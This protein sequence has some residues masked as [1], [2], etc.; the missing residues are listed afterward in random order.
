MY[1]KSK[2]LPCSYQ[3]VS[4]SQ[5]AVIRMLD[6]KQSELG[7]GWGS[8]AVVLLVS[9]LTIAKCN[10]LSERCFVVALFQLCMYTTFKYLARIFFQV[11]KLRKCYKYEK[12]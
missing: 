3:L 2:M 11:D 10:G 4:A 7:T 9:P 1:T 12:I 5:Y 8:Y 6:C